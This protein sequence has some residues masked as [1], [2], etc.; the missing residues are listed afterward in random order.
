MSAIDI[1]SLI[2]DLSKAGEDQK[3]DVEKLQRS[4]T[5]TLKKGSQTRDTNART[6]TYWESEELKNRFDKY[7]FESKQKGSPFINELVKDFLKKS[8]Y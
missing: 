1:N 7:L 5:K 4:T 8:G 3:I 2:G 6:T